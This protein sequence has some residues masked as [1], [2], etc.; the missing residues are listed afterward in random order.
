MAYGTGGASV[1][2]AGTDSLGG[3]LD[4]EQAVSC[5][6]LEQPVVGGDTSVE[7]HRH[8]GAGACSNGSLDSPSVDIHGVAPRFHRHRYQTA[9]AYGQYACN[10]G[11]GRHYYFVARLQ[12]SEFDIAA[13]NKAQGIEA[14][15]YAYGA[16][17]AGECGHTLFE[18]FVFM[19]ADKASAVGHTAQRLLNPGVERL[20]D[21]GKVEKGVGLF[22][23]H[24]LIVRDIGRIRSTT[25]A[26]PDASAARGR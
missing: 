21:S 10:V 22:I 13:Q 19:T 3:I 8:N 16:C 6:Q 14:V 1:L 26:V 18:L 12:T 23:V 4:Y 17:R 9:V 24:L 11:V 20:V 2:V 25:W 7:V 15:A 5:C